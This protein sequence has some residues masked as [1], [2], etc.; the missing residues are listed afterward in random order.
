MVWLNTKVKSGNW[1]GHSSVSD[2]VLA[3]YRGTNEAT[4]KVTGKVG[5]S[6]TKEAINKAVEN[7]T[8]QLTSV[9]DTHFEYD[10]DT[11]GVDIDGYLFFPK[12]VSGSESFS[13]REFIRT[14][15]MS[16]GEFVSRGQ[17]IPREYD[18]ETIIDIDPDELDDYYNLFTTMENKVC[19]ITS[20]YMGGIFK[21]EVKVEL[22]NPEASPHV[23]ECKITIKEIPDVMARLK[24]DPAL[25]YP[26]INTVSDVTVKEKASSVA[27]NDDKPKQRY[28]SYTSSD[29]REY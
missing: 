14:K 11:A 6:D 15:I 3:N 20:P 18:F 7:A 5:T 8:V 29:S 9:L 23:I 21:G 27:S 19:T 2:W 13:H 25:Q 28:D 12:K 24:G 1:G 22:T 17:Y 10:D 4:T 26:S 16:G